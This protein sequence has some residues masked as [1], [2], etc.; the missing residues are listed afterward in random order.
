MTSLNNKILFLLK[1]FAFFAIIG[2]V[3]LLLASC[4]DRVETNDLAII[5]A[6]GIDNS[7]DGQVELSFQIFIPKVSGAGTETGGVSGSSGQKTMVMSH[8]G[9]NI[10]DALSKIQAELSR[11]IFWGI[12][13][14]IIFG[15]EAAKEGI[16]DHMDF[17]LRHPAPRERAFMFVSRGEAKKYL[18][19]NATLERYSAE[20]IRE[21]TNREHG[22]RV[23]LL[24]LDDMLSSDN[25]GAA[26]PYLE[27][28]VENPMPFAKINGTALLKEERMI[29][30]ISEST[31]R[32]LLW[33]R[34][35]VKD[36]TAI[37]KLDDQGEVAIFPIIT[38]VKLI[39][40]IQGEEWKMI[41][42]VKTE[43]SVVQNTTNLDVN[44]PTSL[45][46][47]K[48]AFRQ[49]IESR[50]RAAIK[51]TMDMQVDVV[52]FGKE[53]HQRYPKEWQQVKHRW[54]EKFPEVKVEFII[55]A[56]LQREGYISKPLKE[57]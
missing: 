46:K 12:C 1:S 29:G 24:D 9:K 2:G 3:I 7:E 53:F 31:T 42:K 54:E 48:K 5:T 11:E 47:V 50:I 36:Y 13:K 40:K 16:Q 39:P 43:G 4:W 20:Y 44:D 33:L 18:E 38:K 51:E 52:H 57:R 34:N 25:L 45:E 17:L 15:E 6:A 22:M 35:E 55:D 10:S 26:L 49:K 28:V 27:E 14:V 21:V 8:K 19:L 30:T 32:G 41:I 23:S 56:N 37:I